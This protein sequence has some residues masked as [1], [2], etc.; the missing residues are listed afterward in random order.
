MRRDIGTVLGVRVEPWLQ[1]LYRW[2]AGMP[3]Y[4]VGHVGRMAAVADS[5]SRV[6]ALAVAGAAYRGVGMPDV[7]RQANQ[8]A[9]AVAGVLA[10]QASEEESPRTN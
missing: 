8:A 3:Q 10:G 7:V 9:T 4:T 6:P 2:P 1:R 5:L